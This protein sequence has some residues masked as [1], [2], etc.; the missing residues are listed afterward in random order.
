STRITGPPPGTAGAIRVIEV[1]PGSAAAA[2]GVRAG[3]ELLKVGDID[4]ADANFGAKLRVR[5]AGRP[6]GSPLPLIVKRGTETLTLNGVLAYAASA[7]RIGE[8]PA[9]SA[10]AIRLRTG[11]L[12]GVVDK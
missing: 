5:Y 7:P 11:I 8:D 6:S 4:V 10:R 12:R 2:A 9:A 1:A 3:D